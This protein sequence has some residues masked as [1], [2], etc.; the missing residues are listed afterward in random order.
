MCNSFATHTSFAIT[1]D[2]SSHLFI[3]VTPCLSLWA[4]AYIKTGLQTSGLIYSIAPSI[5]GDSLKSS[6]F[7]DLNLKFSIY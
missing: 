7:P 1:G 2:S 3:Q 4:V 6:R 5:Q